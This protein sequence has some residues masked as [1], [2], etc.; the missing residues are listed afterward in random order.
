VTLA[1]SH[2]GKMG[3]TI[4]V[5]GCA[6]AGTLLILLLPLCLIQNYGP[7]GGNVS[8]SMVT[9]TPPASSPAPLESG[10]DAMMRLHRQKRYLLF[11][12]GSSFQLVFDII[13]PIVDYTNYAILGITCSVAWELPSK[14]P[15]ELIENV[16]TRI[17]DGTIGTVRR[18]GSVSVPDSSPELDP[19]TQSKIQTP[20]QN[21]DV[22][23]RATATGNWQAVHAPPA[24][25]P[26]YAAN[27]QD[28][29]SHSY[30]TNIQRIPAAYPYANANADANANGQQRQA[31]FPANWHARQ[32]LGR[33]QQRGKGSGAATDNWWTRNGQRVQQN[34][35]EKQLKWGPSKWE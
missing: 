33:W 9:T 27:E 23:N 10:K 6:G 12:E 5:I 29:H 7:P 1:A 26:A 13:I 19:Q 21:L 24:N 31:L 15:S 25:P 17:N 35:Q 11:P 34:W 4:K 8:H 20:S 30:Y 16:L 32:S 2:E 18:N 22:D 28:S 14:P 3:K